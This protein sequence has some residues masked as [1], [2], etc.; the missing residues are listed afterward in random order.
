M[1]GSLVSQWAV[2]YML[3]FAYR[4]VK[5]LHYERRGK[6]Y[7]C[8]EHMLIFMDDML[9]IGS[10]RKRLKSAV[11]GLQSYLWDELGFTIKSNW[12]IHDINDDPIDMMGYVVYAGGHVEIRGR[13][14]IRARRMALRYKSQGGFLTMRQCQRI[15][16]YKGYFLYSNS[17]NVSKK[18]RLK[19]IFK[20]AAKKIS[21]EEKRKNAKRKG[22]Q[23]YQT[24]NGNKVSKRRM[25]YGE[26]HC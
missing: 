23:F 17:I 16:S 15:L 12:Q 10:N 1:I 13:D 26:E 24:G 25:P 11:R 3:S 14:F 18:Y 8:V 19:K 7:K 9:L 22:K 5:D 2:Q 21:V 20:Y 6:R 4:Y